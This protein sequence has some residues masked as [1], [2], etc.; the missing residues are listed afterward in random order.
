MATK[1]IKFTPKWGADSVRRSIDYANSGL[2]RLQSFVAEHGEGWEDVLI[3]AERGAE[4]KKQARLK[5]IRSWMDSTHT[6]QY[7]RATMEAQAL[8]DLGQSNLDYWAQ[9]GSY[10][11]VRTDNI[12]S[13][14]CLNLA[15]DVDASGDV[16]RVAQSW[17][18]ARNAEVVVTMPGWMVEDLQAFQNIAKAVADL[19]NK[20]YEPC[21]LCK[22]L[23]Q[24]DDVDSLEKEFNPEI[25]WETYNGSLD[26]RQAK[27]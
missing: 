22:Y 15:E 27:K 7:V 9:L 18:D 3:Y 12:S 23:S 25:W 26:A 10:L 6:P 14:Q 17:I 21:E 11:R 16:W 13:A 2:K 19:G 5:E 24:L 1:E 4:F 8:A 20:G